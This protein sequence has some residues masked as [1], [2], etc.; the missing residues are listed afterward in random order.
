MATMTLILQIVL[1]TFAAYGFW[2]WGIQL[3]RGKTIECPKM[4]AIVM[5]ICVGTSVASGIEHLATLF[6]M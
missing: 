3:W 5:F 1:A 6:K 4:L 2:S